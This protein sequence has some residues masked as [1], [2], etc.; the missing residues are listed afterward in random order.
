MSDEPTRHTAEDDDF[1][2]LERS[3]PRVAP[4]PDLL[5]RIIEQTQ[6][7]SAEARPAAAAPPSPARR[8][9]HEWL[10]PRLALPALGAV[11]A[12]VVVA[13]LLT[14]ISGEDDPAVRVALTTEQASL[15]GT[16]ELFDPQ[17]PEA[18]VEIRLDGLEPAPEGHHYTAW[19]LE[20][21]TGEMTPIG[22]FDSTGATTELRLPLPGPGEYA[23]FDISVQ[24]DSAPPEHSGT[25]VAGA[26][27]S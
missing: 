14:T 23:A 6:V 27:L 24:A 1:A 9:W 16:V 11:A 17:A 10:R 7:P 12:L 25:S 22:S 3:L 20:A 26:S 21:A 5:A 4:P 2:R 13:L 8:P 19:V 18:H 15:S